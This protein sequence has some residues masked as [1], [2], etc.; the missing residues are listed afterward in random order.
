MRLPHGALHTAAHTPSGYLE[1]NSH[2]SGR[3]GFE[4]HAMVVFQV[5]F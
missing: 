4:M 3:D 5:M 1:N 2:G